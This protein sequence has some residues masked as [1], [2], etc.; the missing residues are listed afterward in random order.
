MDKTQSFIQTAIKNL[1]IYSTK[2][3]KWLPYN[4]LQKILIKIQLSSEKLV[5]T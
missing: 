3:Q 5:K 2:R 1:F 4:D